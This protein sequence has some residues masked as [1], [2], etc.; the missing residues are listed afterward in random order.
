MIKAEYPAEPEAD[1][2]RLGSPGRPDH[3]LALIE[4]YG[5]EISAGGGIVYQNCLSFSSGR[6]G[7]RL[8]RQPSLAIH[9]LHMN[10][11]AFMNIFRFLE[12]ARFELLLAV[13]RPTRYFAGNRGERQGGHP[14]AK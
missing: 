9:Q 2:P 4:N 3:D 14:V 1:E 13:D 10:G 12:Q 6:T 11:V 5:S 8:E 7:H